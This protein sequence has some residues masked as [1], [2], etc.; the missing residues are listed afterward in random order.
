MTPRLIT[1]LLVSLASPVGAGEFRL[2]LPVACDLA[3]DCF[4]QQYVDHDPSPGAT[5]FT[6]GA[7]SYDGHKG[8]DFALPSLRA[9][10]EGVTVTA[11]AAGV[12]AGLRDG[13]EDAY[14]TSER[15][16]EIDGRDCGN[17]VV[18]RH[19]DGWET[20]YC[21]MKRGSL[22][23]RK[24]DRVEAGA[25]L[26]EVGLSGRTQFPHLHL[27]VR[28]NGAV[29]DPF[30]PE[31][32]VAAPG[33]CAQTAAADTLWASPLDYAPTG[34]I[35]LGFASAVPSYDAIKAGVADQSPLPKDAP[36]LVLWAYAYGSQPGDEMRITL[37]A[38]DDTVLL[39]NTQTLDRQQSQ[40]FRAAGKRLRAP[41]STGPYQGRVELWRDGALQDASEIAMTPR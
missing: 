10:Q 20:Q 22:L 3:S 29:I 15:A 34:V 11:A 31:A 7:L 38:A 4:I 27:S 1:A 30:R 39:E 16:A 36:A 35:A 18:L 17:G 28:H 21:H 24:G 13:M 23:V 19:P 6:C 14:A 25:P 41:L 26:G 5:D 37:T 2:T 8:T 32:D 9:M 33:S 40:F 12:V